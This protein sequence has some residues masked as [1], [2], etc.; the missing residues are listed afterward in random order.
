MSDKI[1]VAVYYFPN[2]HQDSRNALTHGPGWNEWELT[3]QARSRFPGHQQPKVPLWG[4]EDEADP[5]VMAKKIASAADHGIDCFIFD[6]YHYD[7]GPFLERCLDEGFLG[8]ENHGRLKFAL[9]WANH[10]WRDIHPAPRGNRDHLLYSGLV[11]E[12]T[13]D[14]ICDLVIERYFKHPSYWKINGCPYFSVYELFR[15]MQGF[16]GAEGTAAAI[17]GFRRKVKAAG[18][19]DLHLNTIVYGI[20]LL[21]GEMAVDNP[22][23]LIEKLGFD[24]V[25]SYVWVHH[26]PLP[27]F[28]RTD[29]F[30]VMRKNVTFWHE[31]V[32]AYP[33]PYYPNVMMGWDS[34]PRTIQ[35]DV[36]ENIGYP[37]TP[38]IEASPAMFE[39]A[40]L[41]ARDFLLSQP[42][43]RRILTVNAWNEWTEGSY[44]EPDTV[45]GYG[46]LEAIKR[47]F[48][49]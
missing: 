8:A 48:A 17:A 42:E 23:Q 20:Q 22:E 19:P 46:Y 26:A 25:T 1:Q 24:S 30:E 34:S 41:I 33:L 43:G 40:L 44:L 2:Y 3:R 47:V 29:Y 13:F 32:K 21:P 14:R 10:D 9:M 18:F 28:P 11:A 15:L 37:Y 39:R 45:N 38:A 16:G 36:L 35:S 49:M 31:A 6:W 12:A 4:Y 27:D 7:D 5:A